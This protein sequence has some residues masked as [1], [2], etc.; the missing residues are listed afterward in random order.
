MYICRMIGFTSSY[1]VKGIF[2]RNGTTFKSTRGSNT[3]QRTEGARLAANGVMTRKAH[4]ELINPI[5]AKVIFQVNIDETAIASRKMQTRMAARG[6][7]GHFSLHGA[8]PTLPA[9][10]FGTHTS[11]LTG[12]I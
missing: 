11:L 10:S 5:L 4:L 6:F 9:V 3:M 2:D 1:W 7:A 12:N 8:M